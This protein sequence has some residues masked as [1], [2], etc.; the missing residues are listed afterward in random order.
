MT[1]SAADLASQYERL[2]HKRAGRCERCRELPA[3]R[4]SLPDETTL[5]CLWLD[6][7]FGSTFQDDEGRCVRILDAGEW[8]RGAGPDF[9]HATVEIN[10]TPTHGDIELDPTPEDWERH[11]HG[12]NPAFNQVVLHVSCTPPS[13]TWFTRNS[14]HERI[15]RIELPVEE[16]LPLAPLTHPEA[17]TGACLP[18][19]NTGDTDSIDR[20]LR[21]AAA[22]R[23]EIKKRD[24]KQ[25]AAISGESQTLYE[26]IAETLGY[27]ANK[28]AMGI[29]AR[30]MK[31][32]TVRSTPEP[33]LFGAAGFLIP[34]LP[35][36]CSPQAREYH[37]QLWDLW[38][39]L[40]PD[41]ELSPERSIEWTL[42][43]T[44]P[45]NHP[46]RRLGAFASIIS[47]WDE[48]Q[49]LCLTTSLDSLVNLKGLEK[50]FAS[51]SHPYWSTHSTLPSAGFKNAAA[52]VGSNRVTDFAINHLLPMRDSAEA[53]ETYL[54][55]PGGEPNK[56]AAAMLRRIS[57]SPETEKFL[58]AKAYRQQALLQLRQDF[59]LV[60]PCATCPLP[61]QATVWGMEQA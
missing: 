47:R 13:G 5:Q 56:K 4:E 21:M 29:L 22:Y 20:I 26:S 30:R 16:I 1:D 52:L 53:W 37:K 40:R 9:L 3:L 34:V 7:K 31:L 49:T 35:D 18:L 38:W 27:S 2:L 24:W 6:G 36:R 58:T 46:Q 55:L 11:G 60:S 54:S 12:E 33:L 59:C 10:G 43:G 19:W 28:T 51:L 25:R 39:K 50:W 57:S 8:N 23:F 44:R 32:N 15:P 42:S 17:G 48:F 41:Y 14:R 45:V 61:T